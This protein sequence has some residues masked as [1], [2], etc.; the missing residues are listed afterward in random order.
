MGNKNSFGY[1][2]LE[3]NTFESG[4]T[5][6]GEFCL[7]IAQNVNCEK[8][9]VLLLGQEEVFWE[10]LN[11]SRMDSNNE[12][13]VL[14]QKSLVIYNPPSSRISK[15][16]YIIPFI[17]DLP[18]DLP[19]T[20]SVSAP[21]I[22][23]KIYYYLSAT[24]CGT[25]ICHQLDINIKQTFNIGPTIVETCTQLKGCM[26]IARG[27]VFM[28]VRTDKG[29]YA[30]DESVNNFVDIDVSKT[31]LNV[32]TLE[33]SLYRTITI[34]K[35]N[36]SK[37]VRKDLVYDKNF[38]GGSEEFRFHIHL[39]S[40]ESNIKQAYST[41]GRVIEIGYSVRINGIMSSIFTQYGD[42][43]QLNYWISIIP[44][45][46]A[47]SLPKDSFSWKPKRVDLSSDN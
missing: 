13:E 37:C 36:K 19:A 47:Q 11:E 22:K 5:L 41:K 14:I 34:T 15:G 7:K 30:L 4:E 1:I 46:G 12:Y 27:E 2:K 26:W 40:V 6:Y 20:T 18:Y 33:V 38:S 29:F 35:S 23:G 39:P 17:I 10:E 25:D 8:I 45:T 9:E 31:P 3:K 28:R 32:A 24:V 16:D 43:P 44:K 21:R 42:E